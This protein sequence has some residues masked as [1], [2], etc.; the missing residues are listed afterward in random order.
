MAETGVW[1]PCESPAHAVSMV[2]MAASTS[3]ADLMVTVGDRVVVVAKQKAFTIRPQAT[4]CGCLL[5]GA[6]TGMHRV[7]FSTRSI[8]A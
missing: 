2:S 3:D 8:S 5:K 6:L 1:A 4:G 7:H